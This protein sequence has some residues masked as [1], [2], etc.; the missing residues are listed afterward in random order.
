MERAR[1][2]VWE[3]LQEHRHSARAPT[4]EH[5]LAD[6]MRRQADALL[7]WDLFETAG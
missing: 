1:A 2:G 6:F 3:I 5:D 4:R 7:A